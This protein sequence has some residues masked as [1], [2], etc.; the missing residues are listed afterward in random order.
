MAS[1]TQ[2]YFVQTI[3]ETVDK[4]SRQVG[5][6]ARAT[7]DASRHAQS[8]QG[9]LKMLGGMVIGG[10]AV[11]KAKAAFIDYN[12]SIEQHKV[13]LA[14]M[15]SMYTGAE[16]SKSWDRAGISVERF[17]QMAKKSSLTTKDLVETAAGLTRPLLQAGVKM[18]DVEKLSFGA[19]NA[20][21]AFGIGGSI[22]A[23]D[24][25]QAL[26]SQVGMRDRFARN[27]LSQKEVNLNADQFNALSIDKRVEALKKGLTSKAVTDMAAKQGEDTMTGVMSTLQDNLEIM[28]GKAGGGLFKALTEEIKSWNAWIDKNSEKLGALVDKLGAGLMKAFSI[29][30]EIAAGVLPIL[31]DMLGVVGSVMSFAAE[32]KDV[33]IS[34]AK[35]L[36]VFKGAQ[37]LGGAVLGGVG[38]MGGMIGGAGGP[39]GQ[40]KEGFNGLKNG[41]G[42]LTAAFSNMST[43]LTGAGGVLAGLGKLAITAYTLGGFLFGKTESEKRAEETRAAE[44]LTGKQYASTIS[45]MKAMRD[46]FVQIGVD[47]KENR[48]WVPVYQEYRDRLFKAQ[49]DLEK[50]EIDLV[51]RGIAAGVVHEEITGTGERK[52]SLTSGGGAADE[53]LKSLELYF[54]RKVQ[55]AVMA[56]PLAGGGF[57]SS[58]GQFFGRNSPRG[59]QWAYFFEKVAGGKSADTDEGFESAQIKQTV[60][61]TIQRV[62][63][64]DPNKWLAEMEDMAAHRARAPTRAKGSWKNT[65]K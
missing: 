17:Q 60:N 44:I 50:T 16:I 54:S 43:L 8:L 45:E 35:S 34:L 46:K 23:M 48:D 58:M 31:K 51:R 29:A 38:G 3:Y 24:I 47:P 39:F 9:A 65:P 32:H 64:K 22:A 18:S 62:M 21:K 10:Q 15:L 56:H 30:K 25:E 7:Q 19:A 53:L 4:S 63:A 37:M 27:I 52:L 28:A 20:A 57:D 1:N 2:S 13:I 55:E 59:G 14:G 33:L 40:I 11:M 41:T 49:A 61:I 6:I 36:L 5:E 26:T 12:S 42:S